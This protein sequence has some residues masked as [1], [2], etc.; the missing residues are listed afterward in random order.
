MSDNAAILSC[1]YSRTY[2][3]RNTIPTWDIGMNI[4]VQTER[5]CVFTRPTKYIKT[6][7][8]SLGIPT[9][10]L[11]IVLVNACSNKKSYF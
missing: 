7:P 1:N 4:I 10:F 11:T 5:G 3:E 8:L 6:Y 2:R 9:G